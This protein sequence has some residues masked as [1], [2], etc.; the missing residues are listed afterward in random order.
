MCLPPKSIDLPVIS[1]SARP[2]SARRTPSCATACFE[3]P[4][5]VP[6]STQIIPQ[7]VCSRYGLKVGA[8]SAWF[9]KI[10]MVLCSPIAW[11]IGKLLDFMLGPDH[12]V[13]AAKLGLPRCSPG[14]MDCRACNQQL[15]L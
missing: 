7:A 11:P 10:L 12:S 8:Y 6:A 1:T 15:L 14:C 9:V 2:I 13:G 5:F 4:C 3:T